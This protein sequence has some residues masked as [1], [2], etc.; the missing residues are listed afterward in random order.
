LIRSSRVETVGRERVEVIVVNAP[1][2]SVV[3]DDDLR[4]VSDCSWSGRQ[5]ADLAA[6]ERLHL[7]GRERAQRRRGEATRA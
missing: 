2:W 5:R 7:I 4:V 6:V 3:S 1:S